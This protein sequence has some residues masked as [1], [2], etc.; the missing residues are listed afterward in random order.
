MAS[1]NASSSSVATPPSDNNNSAANAA[2]NKAPAS[3]AAASGDASAAANAGAN[4]QSYASASLYVG[5]LAQTVNEALLFD[6]FSTVGAVASVRVCRDAAT[7]RSLGYAYVNFHQSA[8]AE[9][10]LD[11]MNFTNIH[12]KAC[13]IM[14]SH[15]DPSVRKSG[16][17]NVF[18]KNLAAD[19]DNKVLFDTFSEYGDILSCKVATDRNGQSLGYGF[20]H[21]VKE[22]DAQKALA[23]ANGKVVSGQA[24]T[25]APFKPKS[26]RSG[27]ANSKFTNVYV[28]NLPEDFTDEKLLE[29]FGKHGTVTSHM[30]KTDEVEGKQVCK[31]FGFVNFE[32]PEQAAAAVDAL[33]NFELGDN[34]LYVGRAQ[35]REEREK[36]LRQ[37]HEQLRQERQK[38]YAG[39]NLY[40]KNLHDGIDDDKLREAFAPFGNITSTKVMLDRNGKS[41]GFGFVCFTTPDE[42]AKAVT[43][44]SGKMLEGKP[45]YVALAQRKDERRA[46]LEA[47]YVQR[48]KMGMQGM[49]PQG[50]MFFPHP[51]AAQGMP[52][53][54]Y[55]QPMMAAAA[56]RG[57]QRGPW[58]GQGAARGPAGPMMAGG[59]PPMGYMGMPPQQQQQQQPMQGGQRQGGRGGNQGGRKGGK[60]PRQGGRQQGQQNFKYNDNAR[61][62]RQQQQLQQP[63]Q[64]VPPQQVQQ[65]Q[66]PP[67]Q[68]QRLTI[69]AL[70]AAPEETQKQMI[71]ERLYPLIYAHQPELAGKITGMLLEMDNGELLH[72]IEAPAALK[73]KVD[74]ALTVLRQHEE[75]NGSAE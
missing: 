57:V 63:Q 58:Q 44:M 36:A 68:Q 47:Q 40:I 17:G 53:V 39:V 32:Q 55:P 61:N 52:R 67:P 54:V 73:E 33:N 62:N 16:A 49:Y 27:S 66:P 14:W 75:Q 6:I 22:E 23:E 1:P 35:K 9:R 7:R 13:R 69:Q 24:V 11:T 28:K 10:A 64:Q 34:K 29:L 21:F 19:I 15:R 4:A 20:V 37:R 8:D 60:G 41:R 42:A 50:Q 74:E 38:Q 5:D 59:V 43:E 70:A 56:A 30:L 18:V 3:A 2:N 48:N 72:L 31:G 51:G 26:E 46:Q 65:Q 12:G 71:G 45:L 25:V